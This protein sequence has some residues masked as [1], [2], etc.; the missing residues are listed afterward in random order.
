MSEQFVAT[1]YVVVTCS[2]CGYDYP[3]KAA[4]IDTAVFR[5]PRCQTGTGADLIKKAVHTLVEM[6]EIAAML[7][8]EVDLDDVR[9]RSQKDM[10]PSPEERHEHADDGAGPDDLDMGC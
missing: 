7:G 10:E 6:R 8:P 2:K 1:G 9:V 5:C 4:E 3:L